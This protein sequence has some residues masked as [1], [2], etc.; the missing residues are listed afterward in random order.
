MGSQHAMH[1][2]GPAG[3]GFSPGPL[4]C[5]ASCVPGVF[6]P[7]GMTAA[8]GTSPLGAGGPWSQYTMEQQQGG[9]CYFPSQNMHF[10]APPAVHGQVMP[11]PTHACPSLTTF[12][13]L[14]ALSSAPR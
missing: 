9:G 12:H 11:R 13:T 5:N 3:P 2:G 10:S 14:S 8:A 1:M 6:A 4:A 7:P